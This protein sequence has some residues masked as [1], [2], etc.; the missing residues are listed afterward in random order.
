MV[1]VIPFVKMQGLG[2]DFVVVS[3]E[4]VLDRAMIVRMCDRRFGVGADGV[5]RVSSGETGVRME[6][7]NADGSDAEMCGNGLRCVA[8]YAHDQGLA[9]GDEFDVRT[10][11]G[12][13]TTRRLA[14]DLVEV[15]LGPVTIGDTVVIHERDYRL[16]SVGNP[17]AVTFVDDPATVDVAE[18]G[19]RVAG[20]RALFPHG[21]NVEFVRALDASSIRMRVWERGIGETQACGTGI[22]ASAAVALAAGYVTAARITVE[23]PGGTAAVR[24]EGRAT[25]LEGPAMYVFEGGFDPR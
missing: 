5:L 12:P 2:N 6:Y 14:D 21:T 17:H 15:D 10:P 4:V 13:R 9:D 23:A 8:R 3:G 19:A 1:G 18:V 24:I 20:D 7:W 22:A 16:A 25:W 11:I